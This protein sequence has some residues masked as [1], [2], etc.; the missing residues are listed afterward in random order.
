MGG[1]CAAACHTSAL[2]KL[3]THG[4]TSLAGMGRANTVAL[5]QIAAEAHQHGAVFDR[6]HAFG[7]H[8]QAEG[9]GQPDRR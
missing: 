9:T 4:C 5:Y 6:L 8:A 3:S 2:P 1:S 7:D